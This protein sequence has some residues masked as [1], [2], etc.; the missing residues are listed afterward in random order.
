MARHFG[1]ASRSSRT[2]LATLRPVVSARCADV[3]NA[4][5]HEKKLLPVSAASSR[6][7]PPFVSPHVGDVAAGQNKSTQLRPRVH[8]PM[9]NA[10][11]GITRQM[12]RIDGI[13]NH[14]STESKV[15]LGDC[16]GDTIPSVV[17]RLAQ[18]PLEFRMTRMVLESPAFRLRGRQAT[19]T[20]RFWTD[21]RQPGSERLSLSSCFLWKR[22]AGVR[23]GFFVVL[24]VIWRALT[25]LHVNLHPNDWN[26][27]I[28][29]AHNVFPQLRSC[30]PIESG[31]GD[32]SSRRYFRPSRS[33]G[34]HFHRPAR[35]THLAECR[36]R[37][38]VREPNR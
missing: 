6:R 37:N 25:S 31:G 19:K 23:T 3:R 10:D 9:R 18:R 14:S 1:R 36:W 24:I 2:H 29:L 4:R 34:E 16:I 11:P 20:T 28:R 17:E 7:Y 21:R 38:R 13:R 32:F 12:N 15:V 33:P 26:G 35:A 27:R 5:I 22:Y 8:R 30:A